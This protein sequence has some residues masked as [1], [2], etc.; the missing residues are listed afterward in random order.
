MA[1]VKVLTGGPPAQRSVAGTAYN[2]N[3]T[4]TLSGGKIDF[5]TDTMGSGTLKYT[6]FID[7]KGNFYTT[8]DMDV[9]GLYPAI[10]GTTGSKSYMSTAVSTGQCNSCHGVSTSKIWS[11]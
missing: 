6:V 2:A 9:N 11:N 5:Y 1:R 3:E 10:T 4:N 8:A 7:E